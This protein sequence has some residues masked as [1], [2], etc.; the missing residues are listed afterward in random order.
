MTQ[1]SVKKIKENSMFFL[2]K[3]HGNDRKFFIIIGCY[4]K[5]CFILI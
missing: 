4:N 3:I 5:N 1:Y 2:Y